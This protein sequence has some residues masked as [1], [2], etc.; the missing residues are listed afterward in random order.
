MVKYNITLTNPDCEEVRLTR[1]TLGDALPLVKSSLEQWY[2]FLAP[3]NLS[4]HIMANL[5]TR[6]DKCY[7]HL[8]NL[9]S[10][11]RI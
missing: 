4:R 7:S 11:V 9:I 2:P 3:I 6:P 10:I 8:S 5:V 1:V